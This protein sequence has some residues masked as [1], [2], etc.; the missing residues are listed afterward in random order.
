[1]ALEGSERFA[2][3]L[4]F[5]DAPVEVGAPLGLVLGADD[6]D[7]VDRV[8]DLAIAAAVEPVSDGLARGGWQWGGSVAAGEGGLVLEARRSQASS[9]P[10]EI[11]PIPGSSRSVGSR[12]RTSSASWRS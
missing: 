11:G 1:V 8:V 4:A 3:G 10:A 6:R 9:F 7:R 12:E 2:L 5:A